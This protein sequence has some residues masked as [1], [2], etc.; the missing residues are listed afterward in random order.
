MELRLRIVQYYS[1]CDMRSIMGTE[2]TMLMPNC[3]AEM[4]LTFSKNES[5]FS[6]Q[7]VPLHPAKER[8]SWRAKL[9][10]ALNCK[11]EVGFFFPAH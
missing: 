8:E 7:R 2:D 5:S 1:I 4:T 3:H 10:W 9:H 6:S 11:G